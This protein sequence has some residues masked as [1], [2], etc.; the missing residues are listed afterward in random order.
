MLMLALPAASG[1]FRAASVLKF[2]TVGAL[3][4][5]CLMP[6]NFF[7]LPCHFPFCI[8]FFFLWSYFLVSTMG[9]DA[10]FV[11]KRYSMLVYGSTAYMKVAWK[12]GP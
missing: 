4:V 8:V 9:T 1:C 6:C 12:D 10:G 11:S 3:A 2:W 5:T 7:F